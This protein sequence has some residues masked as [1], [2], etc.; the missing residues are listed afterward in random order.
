MTL[1]SVLT[2]SL[3]IN[4]YHLHAHALICPYVHWIKILFTCCHSELP[5]QPCISHLDLQLY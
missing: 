4:G 1:F 5:W 3:K 2:L